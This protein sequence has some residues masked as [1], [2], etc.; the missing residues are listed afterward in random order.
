M[1]DNMKQVV[2]YKDA[3]HILITTGDGSSRDVAQLIIGDKRYMVMQ[4]AG[5]TK[6]MDMDVMLEQMKQMAAMYGDAP[7]ADMEPSG[8]PDFEIIKKGEHKTV[9]GVEGEVWTVE[10]EE[11]GKKKQQ[12]IVVTDEE[13]VVD[14]IHKY[15]GAMEKFAKM[16]GSEE[17][18]SSVFDI[19][20]GYVTIA[21]EGMTLVKYDDSDIPDAVFV[22][23]KG[24]DMGAK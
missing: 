6:Y 8:T 10:F 21:F 19:A 18:I 5:K 11:D 4:E 7:E 14:A 9:A 16:G 15:V 24:M 17:D 3:Q 13:E 2:Q 22:L 20:D 12:D 1:Q 23:P